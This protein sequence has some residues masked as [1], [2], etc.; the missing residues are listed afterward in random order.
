[1]V[2]KTAIPS[3]PQTVARLRKKGI[4]GCASGNRFSVIFWLMITILYNNVAIGA[5]S[6][7]VYCLFS[8]A[9]P[10]MNP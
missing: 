10:Q 6:M 8:P 1:M 2:S 5:G 7:S 9:M 3:M 4:P